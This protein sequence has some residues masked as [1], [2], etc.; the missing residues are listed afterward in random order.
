MDEIIALINMI[1]DPMA[2][3]RIDKE[4]SRRQAKNWRQKKNGEW[5]PS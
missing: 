5:H 4:I 3:A 2:E 1:R